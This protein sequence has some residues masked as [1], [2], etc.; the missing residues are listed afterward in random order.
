[1]TTT[2]IYETLKAR[3][4]APSLRDFSSAF[5]GKADNYAADRGLDECSPTALLN[6]HYRLG[7]IGQIDLQAVVRARLLDAPTASQK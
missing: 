7:E 2:E 3:G 5:L 6:L 4:L 1:M